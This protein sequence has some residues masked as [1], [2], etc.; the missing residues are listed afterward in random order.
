M[1][2]I[3]YV[4]FALLL[5]FGCVGLTFWGRWRDWSSR[6]IMWLAF[7]AMAL[8]LLVMFGSGYAILHPNE[9]FVRKIG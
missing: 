3:N 4:Q 8:G 9:P 2:L 7:V 1:G 5:A 6:T